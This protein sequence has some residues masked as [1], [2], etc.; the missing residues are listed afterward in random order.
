MSWTTDDLVTAARR[1]GWLPDASDVAASDLLAWGDE[2]IA[3][4]FVDLLKTGR[5]E[6]GITSA[7]VALVSGTARY[8]LPRRASLRSV[9]GV[10]FIDSSGDEAPAEELP[11]METWRYSG[12]RNGSSSAFYRFEGD[13][14]VLAVA[15]TTSGES[16]RVRYFQRPSVMI[17]T[18]AAA[19][20]VNAVSTVSIKYDVTATPPSTLTTANALIDV[21]RGDSPF[22]TLYED[23]IVASWSSP[24]VTLDSTTPIVVAEVSSRGSPA[25]PGVRVDYVCPRDS[26]CYPPIPQ[27]MHGALAWGIVSRAL[28]ATAD[29][30]FA[31]AERRYRTALDRLR[32]A[33]EPRNADRRPRIIDR[34]SRLRG[35]RWR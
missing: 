24:N 9:R 14:I 20:I 13:E 25:V 34:G 23:L 1:S 11:A 15:P 26:T 28:E 33:A 4:D 12:S 18:S 32:N 21:V 29:Q 5:E 10:S 30:R 2:C 8:R 22:P 35:G 27:E 31:L 17:A 16:L 3:E 6:Y 19:P 7:D